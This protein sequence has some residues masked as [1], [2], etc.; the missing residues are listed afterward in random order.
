MRQAGC[1]SLTTSISSLSGN[2]SVCVISVT[3]PWRA[4]LQSSSP[5]NFNAEHCKE[6]NFLQER[7]YWARKATAAE[8]FPR[9]GSHR[10]KRKALKKCQSSYCSQH[11][12][13]APGEDARPALGK[14]WK[15]L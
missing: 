9:W 8:T 11:R 1:G 12:V 7:E 6:S 10:L 14:N 4:R 2:W 3:T 5:P 13:T 15:L